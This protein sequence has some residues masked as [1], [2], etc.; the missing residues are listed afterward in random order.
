MLENLLCS[1]SNAWIF[2]EKHSILIQCEHTCNLSMPTS[3]QIE[4]MH[5]SVSSGGYT[6][7]V[8]SK[9]KWF[10]NA[11]S[12]SRIS[13]F[14]KSVSLGPLRASCK[15]LYKFFYQKAIHCLCQDRQTSFK[16]SSITNGLSRPTYITMRIYF[17]GDK[18]VAIHIQLL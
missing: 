7:K 2:A 15:S 13:S 14:L 18:D 1:L 3:S 11:T 16:G 6:S 12:K 5:Q 9:T 8:V 4:T 10:L 17:P